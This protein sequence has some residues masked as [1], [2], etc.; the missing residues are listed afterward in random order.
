MG[1]SCWTS[2]KD[3]ELEPFILGAAQTWGE[4]TDFALMYKAEEKGLT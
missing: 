1:L 2:A 3:T 4:R